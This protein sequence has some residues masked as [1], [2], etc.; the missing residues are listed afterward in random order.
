MVAGSSVEGLRL[1]VGESPHEM[2]ALAMKFTLNYFCFTSC[3]AGNSPC[4]ER[5]ERTNIDRGCK[6]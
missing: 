2:L 1:N 3:N 4:R 5:S 6:S